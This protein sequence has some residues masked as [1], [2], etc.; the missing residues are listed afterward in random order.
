MVE[1]K[2]WGGRPVGGNGGQWARYGFRSV[3]CR[4]PSVP[5]LCSCGQPPRTETQPR[6]VQ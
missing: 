5:P 6:T 1:V 4:S 3:P 2:K